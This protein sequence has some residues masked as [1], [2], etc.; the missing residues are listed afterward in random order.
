MEIKHLLEWQISSKK[1]G[2]DTFL[3][4]FEKLR[5]VTISFFMSVCTSVCLHEAIR[6]PEDGF[7]FDIPDLSKICPGNSSFVET[8]KGQTV[9]YMKTYLCNM[10]ITL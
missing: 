2:G 6:L 1:G 4:P 8:G 10:I 9:P 7:S 3:G 5:E